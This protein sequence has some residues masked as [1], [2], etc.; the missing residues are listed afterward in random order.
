[1][2]DKTL[3]K[4]P[5]RGW[6]SERGSF[7]SYWDSSA[8]SSSRSSSPRAS[9]GLEGPDL[10]IARLRLS[11]IPVGGGCRHH[12]KSGFERLKEPFK[13]ME[14]ATTLRPIDLGKGIDSVRAELSGSVRRCQDTLERWT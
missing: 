14:I 1:M 12:G 11:R 4:R 10:G 5:S 3:A 6:I 7:C 9:L 8:R 2:Q 13:E